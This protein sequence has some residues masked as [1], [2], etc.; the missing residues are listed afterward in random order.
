MVDKDIVLAKIA[1]IQ[2]C[3][4]RIKETTGLDPNSLENV[5]TQDIFV[6]NLQRAIQ[7]LID[8]AAHVVGSEGWNLPDTFKGNFVILFQKK[9]INKSISDKMQRMV[10]FR[11]IAVHDYQNIDVEILKNILRS[12]LADLE[13]FY[14]RIVKHYKL[15]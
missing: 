1:I 2:R 5:D 12:N 10:G 6:L 14:D 9:I 3:L 11:N 15:A 8:I 13:T 7:A 4:Q